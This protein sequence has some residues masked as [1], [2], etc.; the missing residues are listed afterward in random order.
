[1]KT[2]KKFERLI[3]SIHML[4]SQDAVVRW[5]EKINGRQ[6]DVTIRFKIGLYDYLTLIECKDYTTAVPVK[7][8]EAFVTK[9]KGAKAN[10]SIIVTSSGFQSGCIKVAQDN[11]IELLVL[12]EEIESPQK[13]LSDRIVQA[14][15]IYDVCLTKSNG[16]EHWLPKEPGGRIEFLMKNIT[17]I[18][19]NETH[20]LEGIFNR[21]QHDNQENISYQPRD[22]LMSF[23]AKTECKLPLDE[24]KFDVVRLKFKCRF[25]KA[26]VAKEDSLNVHVQKKL[27]SIYC[28]MEP[29]GRVRTQLPLYEVKLGFDTVL[30]EGCFYED[31]QSGFFYYCEAINDDKVDILLIESYQHGKL[32]AAR[33]KIDVKY[34]NQYIEV[35]DRETLKRLNYLLRKFNES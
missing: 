33:M 29:D 15:N 27:E 26:Q 7:E 34:S 4:E 35:K 8:V 23:K 30:Q 20:S 9:S 12:K 14:L 18:S 19:G 1:M 5:D 13:G 11:N 21:W 3:A 16:E 32:I 10:K 25:M 28:L 31:P 6:Y 24:G 2:G 22:F 17:L